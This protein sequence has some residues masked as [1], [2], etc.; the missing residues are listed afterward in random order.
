M[1]RPRQPLGPSRLPA[2]LCAAAALLAACSLGTTTTDR[3]SSTA[4]CIEAFGPGYRCGDSGYCDRIPPI[5]RCTAEGRDGLPESYPSD[6]LTQPGEYQGAILLGSLQDLSVPRQVARER[7]ARLAVQHANHAKAEA[8]PFG[9]L[10]CNLAE[11]DELDGLDSKAASERIARHLVE[12]L[13]V[14]ALIGPSSSANTGAAFEAVAD[15]DVVLI[16]PSATAPKLSDADT[17]SP[18]DAQPGKLWRTAPPDQ[19]QGD[20]I[21]ADMNARSLSR[22]VIIFSQDSYGQGLSDV[23]AESFEGQSTKL[24]FG[25]SDARIQH[26]RDAVIDHDPDEVLFI[27]SSASEIA[28]FLRLASEITEYDGRSIFLTDAARSEALLEETESLDRFAGRIRGTY[29][30]P[31]DYS[32]TAAVT[33]RARYEDEYGDDPTGQSYTAQ[34]YDATWLAVYGSVYSRLHEGEVNGTGIARGIRKL[35]TQGADRLDITET[36]FAKVVQAFGDDQGLD[37]DGAS[38]PLDYDLRTEELSAP[39]VVWKVVQQGTAF[40]FEDDAIF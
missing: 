26:T 10:M 35:A 11:D 22:I 29:P 39:I 8:R 24:A 4:Q 38:G 15:H 40:A 33:F 2:Q 37:I 14:A 13:G 9:L 12:D 6:L 31:P 18:S 20:A 21:A 23:V 3:C 28:S 34:T 25:N 27:S 17:D 32:S 30:E 7:A 1:P 16:S 36:N 19:I 5:A